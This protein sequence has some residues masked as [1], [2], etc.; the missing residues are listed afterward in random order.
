MAW[1]QL[2]RSFSTITVDDEPTLP[3]TDITSME[4]RPEAIMRASIFEPRSSSLLVVDLNDAHAFH[5]DS[6][7]PKPPHVAR[8]SGLFDSA[9]IERFRTMPGPMNPPCGKPSPIHGLKRRKLNNFLPLQSLFN[10]RPAKR[11]MLGRNLTQGFR[12]RVGNLR[13]AWRKKLYSDP[14]IPVVV[15]PLLE[16]HAETPASEYELL[17]Y[18]ATH[19]FNFGEESLGALIY[20]MKPESGNLP[21]DSRHTP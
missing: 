16:A 15:P 19:E 7:A 20:M 3:K 18:I 4:I 6:S 21:N 11:T 2:K 12:R 10:H 8:P 5:P 1:K 17:H 14:P 9:S 13:S